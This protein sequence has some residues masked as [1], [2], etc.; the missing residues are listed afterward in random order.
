MIWFILLFIVLFGGSLTLMIRQRTEKRE[1]VLVT[2]LLL[3]GFADW[4]SVFLNHKFKSSKVIALLI[5][6]VG[7]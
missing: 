4:M 1:I 2:A 3:L 5:D 6:L 7:L